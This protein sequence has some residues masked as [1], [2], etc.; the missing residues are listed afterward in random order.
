MSINAKSQ[1]LELLDSLGSDRSCADYKSKPIFPNGP[2]RST[3]E[4]TFADGCRVSGTGVGQ[5]IAEAEVL[6]SQVVLDLL[7][8]NYRYLFVDWETVLIDAQ[9][10]D[11]LI[12][13][14]AYLS[15]SG[16]NSSEKSESLQNV[17]SNFYLASVFDHWKSLG[18]RDLAMWGSNLGKDKKATLVESLLWRRFG[19]NLITDGA[20]QQLQMLLETLETKV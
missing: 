7:H 8:T 16:K 18:D 19:S 4:V 12:K 10:G 2:H 11:A 6:A 1:L 14:G 17:E 3:L 13:L 9:A 5:S 20:K 15:P